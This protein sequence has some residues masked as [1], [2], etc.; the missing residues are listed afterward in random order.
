MTARL[1][2]I[3]TSR[4]HEPSE[5]TAKTR[6]IYK[7]VLDESPTLDKGNFTQIHPDDVERMFDAYDQSFFQGECR[8]AIGSTPLQF[9]LSKRMTQAGGK[10]G[11]RELRRWGAVVRRE[12]EIAISTTLL[13][14]TFED[15]S[16]PITVTGLLCRD[17]LEALQRVLEH[18]MV[19]LIE[20]LLWRDSSCAAS[21][22]Q[23]IA[24]SH[25]GHVEH[26][27]QLI[28]PRERALTKFGIR[29]GDRVTFRV[30]GQSFDG[31]VNRI[32]RRATVLVED[33]AGERYSNG[34]CYR[35]FY[36]PLAMLR[37]HQP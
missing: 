21:R 33:S 12:Y 14:Q 19:H 6:G 22:F 32:T 36:V 28:T 29:A 13:F 15:E 27:H 11:R 17:R 7:L 3:V 37:R 1:Q 20:M 9:R 4:K 35:K 5:I 31:V 25:F 18:E 23:T 30:D 10:T 24:H 2:R 26:T 16:R 8:H 34:R